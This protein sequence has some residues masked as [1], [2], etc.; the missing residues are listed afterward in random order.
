AKVQHT[1]KVDLPTIWPARMQ[2]GSRTLLAGFVVSSRGVEGKG[3]R[4]LGSRRLRR[5]RLEEP[6]TALEIRV[7]SSVFSTL[8]YSSILYSLFSYTLLYSLRVILP[9]LLGA[10]STM[11]SEER[12]VGISCSYWWLVK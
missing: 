11:R 7:I 6:P 5:Q 1:G 9:S 3:V 2:E 4:G 8:L 12:R 10:I